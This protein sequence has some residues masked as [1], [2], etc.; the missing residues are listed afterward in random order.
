M[1]LLDSTYVFDPEAPADSDDPIAVSDLITGMAVDEGYAQADPVWFPSLNTER[2]VHALAL[3]E[4][5][6]TAPFAYMDNVIGL[7]TVP[8]ARAFWIAW[9]T[10][11]IVRL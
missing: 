1:H 10:Q 4:E 8:P 7:P 5:G 9:Q 11:G 3:L 6:Q 2:E